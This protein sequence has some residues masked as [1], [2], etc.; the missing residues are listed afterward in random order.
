[1]TARDPFAIGTFTAD[2][3]SQAITFSDG[4]LPYVNGFQLREVTAPVIPEPG[5]ALFGLALL[6][7][8]LLRRR[9]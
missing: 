6:G 1:M 3:P 9:K 5:T 7:T 8:T 4:F 2:V